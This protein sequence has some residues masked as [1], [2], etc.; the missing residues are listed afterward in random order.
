M[1]FPG[2]SFSM[3]K[4]FLTF[5]S[6]ARYCQGKKITDAEGRIAGRKAQGAARSRSAGSGRSRCWPPWA[7]NWRPRSLEKPEGHRHGCAI[8]EIHQE[9]QPGGCKNQEASHDPV[10]VY[11]FS[12]ADPFSRNCRRQQ[13]SVPFWDPPRALCMADGVQG[14]TRGPSR[15]LR[16]RP[17]SSLAPSRRASLGAACGSKIP[18]EERKASRRGWRGGEIDFRHLFCFARSRITSYA[19]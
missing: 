15:I 18:D 9:A 8:D 19:C 11:S 13:E 12:P 14:V 5:Y 2:K 16:D 17:R 10:P 4:L 6:G 3:E 1:I 7:G